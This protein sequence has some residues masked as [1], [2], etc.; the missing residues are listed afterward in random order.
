[1]A[2]LVRLAYYPF[3]PEVR[4]TVRE[5][6]PDIPT[7]LASPTYQ[8][9]RQRGLTRVEGGL[10]DGSFP[11]ATII[12]DRSALVELLSIPVARMICVALGERFV[13]QRYAEAEAA[14]AE[15]VLGEDQESA[16][17]I[18]AAALQVPLHH[19]PADRE[20]PWHIHYSDYLHLAPLRET[21]WKLVQ[22]PIRNGTVLLNRADAS[23]LVAAVLRDRITEELLEELKRPL[24][25]ELKTALA[26]LLAPL[27]PKIKEARERMDEGDFGPVQRTLFPPCYTM[28]LQQMAEGQMVAHH[29]RFALA[30]FL[31]TIGM[32]AEGIIDFFREIPNFNPEKSR[33]QLQ[34]IAGELGVE[35][36]TPPGCDW[37]QTNGVCPLDRR[38]NLCFKIKHP[39]S[40]YRARIRFQKQDQE[41]GR[42]A[43]AEAQALRAGLAK[44]RAE[45]AAKTDESA[46]HAGRPPT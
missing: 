15:A 23:H 9:A 3:L 20:L 27:Q 18:A 36:Y 44:A 17:A 37:M 40:Y 35:K 25:S 26:P 34:H 12:D 33:Y 41:Q 45:K 21:G 32:N 2:E 39:L 38:D 31:A 43:I 16:I 46:N 13:I 19:E 14:R 10:G 24:P 7:L 11:A 30:S 6:G 4:Q 42:A 8:S 29:G 5:L 22:R 1:M 28:L